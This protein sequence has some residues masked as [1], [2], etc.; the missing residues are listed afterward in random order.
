MLGRTHLT[1]NAAHELRT[2]L[3]I[4]TA[5]LENLQ[6]GQEVERLRADAARMNRLVEQLLRV[7]RLDASPMNIGAI[8]D[9]RAIAAEVVEYLAPWAIAQDRA[10]GFDAPERAIEDDVSVLCYERFPVT[11]P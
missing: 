10:L 1:A 9:L 8:I 6:D 7:A 3:A 4:L 5:G 11:Y 2:P